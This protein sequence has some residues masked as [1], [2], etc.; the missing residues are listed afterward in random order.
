MSVFRWATGC[1]GHRHQPLSLDRL[2]APQRGLKYTEWMSQLR[3]EEVKRI[4]SEHR[5]WTNE[6]IADVCGFTDCSTFQKKFKQKTGMTPAE[7]AEQGE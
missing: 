7:W 6:A 4:I 2:A 1:T 3:I 5:D